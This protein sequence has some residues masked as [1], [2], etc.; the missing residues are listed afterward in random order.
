MRCLTLAGALRERGSACSFVCRA[1][2]G[3]LLDLIDRLDYEVNPLPA[4]EGAS[5]TGGPEVLPL[6]AHA[7]WLEAGW[8]TDASQTRAAMKGNTADWLVVDHYALDS[9]WERELRPACR[10]LMVIDD[11]ADRSHDCDLLLDQNL[12]REAADYAGLVPPDSMIL[13]GPKYALLRPEFA[14]LRP[15]SLERRTNAQLRRLL[16][17]MG[18]I[19]KGNYTGKVLAALR[20]CDLPANFEITVV[21]GSRAPW[22]DDVRTL[23]ATSPR[24]TKVLV[25]VSDMAQLM[26]DSDL[27]IGAAG[28]T[29]LERCCLGLPSLVGILAENQRAGAKALQSAGAASIFDVAAGVSLS[30]LLSDL[31]N[32]GSL[33][34]MA[35][36]CQVIIDGQGASRVTEAMIDA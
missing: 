28:S 14:A 4:S 36:A 33:A 24:P 32:S 10:R 20:N 30:D 34:R 18:G 11:L 7:A 6:P 23:A 1:L 17:T 29:A 5:S 22:I 3:H 26:A 21:M 31:G 9:H 27:A 8:Q 19:D 35:S 12:G 2:P 25:D 15:Y 16:I 13:V